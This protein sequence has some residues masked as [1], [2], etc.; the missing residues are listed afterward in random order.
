MKLSRRQWSGI[1]KLSNL[2]FLAER[3]IFG[4]QHNRVLRKLKFIVFSCFLSFSDRAGIG[5]VME[6]ATVCWLTIGAGSVP[7]LGI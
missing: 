3:T 7:L 6:A 1:V 5:S 4:H 2:H